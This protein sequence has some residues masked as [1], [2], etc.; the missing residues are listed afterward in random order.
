M[1]QNAKD[2]ESLTEDMQL[3]KEKTTAVVEVIST[4]G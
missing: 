3:V 2:I 4:L 1:N